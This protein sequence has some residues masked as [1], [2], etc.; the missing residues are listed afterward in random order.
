MGKTQGITVPVSDGGW[1]F[2]FELTQ[3]QALRLLSAR[4]GETVKLN[5]TREQITVLTKDRL[6]H[7]QAAKFLS[8]DDGST[9]E[10][11]QREAT[12]S[13]VRRMLSDRAWDSN[14]EA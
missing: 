2:S 8:D 4:I 5:G 3:E 11:L 7:T 6:L 9:L 12:L 10:G 13:I 14:K 1:S